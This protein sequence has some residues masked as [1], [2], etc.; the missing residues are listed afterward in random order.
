MVLEDRLHKWLEDKVKGSVLSAIPHLQSN[1]FLVLERVHA[2]SS[3]EISL[4]LH[5][6]LWYHHLSDDSTKQE[7][8]VDLKVSFIKGKT[9][10]INFENK[11]NLQAKLTFSKNGDL[12][13]CQI[14]KKVFGRPCLTFSDSL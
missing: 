11:D 14:D 5:I 2:P 8:S 1:S 12:L 10:Q 3:Q 6:C 13:F 4:K 7:T 9:E